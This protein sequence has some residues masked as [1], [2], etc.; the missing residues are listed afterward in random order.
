M[1]VMMMT[2]TTSVGS[3]VVRTLE[4]GTSRRRDAL[5][6]SVLAQEVPLRE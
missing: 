3:V 5:L 2:T 4:V 6:V 1:S